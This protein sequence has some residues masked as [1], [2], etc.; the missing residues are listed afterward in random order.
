MKKNEKE[1]KIKKERKE[2]KPKSKKIL[3]FL[4]I[5]VGLE[6]CMIPCFIYAG[7]NQWF[8]ITM[9]L[10]IPTISAI[11]ILLLSRNT[12]KESER[13]K[14]LKEEMQKQEQE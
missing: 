8:P 5:L 13:K 10:L 14:R 2:K 12:L 7:M 6:I 9:F 3:I 4:F 1:E 11:V